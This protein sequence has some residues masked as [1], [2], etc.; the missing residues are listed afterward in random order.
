MLAAASAA[1]TLVAIIGAPP[2][3]SLAH[4][5]AVPPAATAAPAAPSSPAAHLGDAWRH[6]EAQEFGA[7][8][9]IAADIDRARLIHDDYALYVMA[10]SAFF[11]GRHQDALE[12]FRALAKRGGSRFRDDAR[13]RIADCLWELASWRPAQRAYRQ[14]VAASAGQRHPAGDV[15]LAHYRL[16]EIEAKTGRPKR[17]VAALQRFVKDYPAHPMADLAMERL[18]QLGGAKAA[19]LSPDDRIARAQT[20]KADRRWH[21]A[22]AELMAI[23]DNDVD[24]DTRRERD[25]WRGMTLFKMRRRYAHA[26]EELL[27]LYPEMGARAAKTLFHGARALSRADRDREA[28]SWYQRV[29]REFP[30]S[31]WAAEAQ[32]LSGW[33]AFN[34]RDYRAAI[35]LLETTQRRYRDSRWSESA[36]WFLGF[37]HFM[38]G[39]YQAA[40]PYFDT[41]ARDRDRLVGGK[42]SYWR[43][44]ALEELGQ[45]GAAHSAYRALVGAHPFSWYALLAQARLRQA[46]IA[47]G[48]FGDTTRDPARVPA[49]DQTPDPALA[50]D[51]LIRAADELLAAGLKVEAGV[52]LRRGEYGFL[53]RHPK[54]KAMATLMD[55]YRRADNFN[56]PWM[57]SVVHGGKN[58][59]N[60]PPQGPARVWWE[61]A[62]PLAYRDLVESWRPLGKNPPYYL[63]AIMRKES[64]F[65]PHIVS[66]ADARG[67]LQMIPPTTRKVA[68]NLGIEYTDDLLYAPTENVRVGSWYIGRLLAKFKHQIPIAA[69]SYNGGPRAVMRWLEKNGQHPIDEFVELVS[70]RQ[71]RGY[72]KKVTETYARYL[73]LYEG[74]VY[75][76]PLTLDANYLRDD[77]N[78]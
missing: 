50:S 52:E 39:E 59:L 35:P 70:Y 51:P 31:S 2:C 69:G 3:A 11:L 34:L 19:R 41:L 62:Y 14:R 30:R 32:F 33:L 78:Y 24:D 27:R 72:M 8:Y 53:R 56:R 26:G 55:R 68:Q 29:V 43:G 46:G 77:I 54:P 48:P 36:G 38:L 71:A 64:G 65:N 4:A 22:F 12:H 18:R 23:A 42:G 58:T 25:Y 61:H 45:T 17:A 16:A 20:L 37:S 60:T 13:W 10:Q 15:G 63:Y 76:Q 57:L 47:I 49:I 5:D 1:A 73:Y 75:E 21:R 44:R 40:L 6:F 66:H 7:A 9:R 74:T 28:I 67:L